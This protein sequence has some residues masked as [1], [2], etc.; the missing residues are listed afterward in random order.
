MKHGGEVCH[1]REGSGNT[2][3]SVCGVR[4]CSTVPTLGPFLPT[5][6]LSHLYP[7]SQVIV[8]WGV[9]TS[10]SGSLLGPLSHRPEVSLEKVVGTGKSCGAR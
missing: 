8:C 3:F 9:C 4:L 6:F 1:R 10:T 2:S 5:Q 7:S